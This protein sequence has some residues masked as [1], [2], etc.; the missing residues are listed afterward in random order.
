MESSLHPVVF[1]P[2]QRV[3]FCTVILFCRCSPKTEVWC[4]AEKLWGFL[5]DILCC[6]TVF[7]LIQTCI[8]WYCCICRKFP[9]VDNPSV[10]LHFWQMVCG[11][12][13]CRSTQLP[14][15][16]AC[17]DM[18]CCEHNSCLAS[19]VFT[20]SRRMVQRGQV[21]AVI[22]W[23]TTS[24]SVRTSLFKTF[25]WTHW[26]WIWKRKIAAACCNDRDCIAFGN[27]GLLD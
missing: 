12:G 22:S 25:T 23:S 3:T 24:K 1:T 26:M 20:F 21:G 7:A 27:K 11:G 6:L 16:R 8:H 19:E 4:Y 2:A 17:P 5:M 13:I 14:R 9:Q 18:D 10:A 15:E